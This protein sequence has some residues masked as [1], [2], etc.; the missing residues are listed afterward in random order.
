[1]GAIIYFINHDKKE[2]F[3]LGKI[4]EVLMDI[5]LMRAIIDNFLNNWNNHHLSILR[6]TSSLLDKINIKEYKKI[7]LS[8]DLEDFN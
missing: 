4:R 2:Y 6:S 1:M 8:F 7:Q 3:V 5:P